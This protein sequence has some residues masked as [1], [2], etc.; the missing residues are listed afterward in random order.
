MPPTT[1]ANT[2]AANTAASAELAT[3]NLPMG[4]HAQVRDS[5]Q[6]PE[7]RTDGDGEGGCRKRPLAADCYWPSPGTCV[8]PLCRHSSPRRWPTRAAQLPWSPGS[9]QRSRIDVPVCLRHLACFTQDGF[10]RS[11]VDQRRRQPARH[12]PHP[13]GAPT[14]PGSDRARGHPGARGTPA[15][16]ARHGERQRECAA[17][18]LPPWWLRSHGR[19]SARRLWTERNRSAG[20]VDPPNYTN[21]QPTRTPSNWAAPRSGP[22]TWRTRNRLPAQASAEPVAWAGIAAMRPRV[23]CRPRDP[24]RY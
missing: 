19:H 16:A 21:R 22:P 12:S 10:R 13:A 9:D 20:D 5:S 4:I 23:R 24:V 3:K 15:I 11:P 14:R 18:R 7:A 17:A 8:V 1:T 2:A 6:W